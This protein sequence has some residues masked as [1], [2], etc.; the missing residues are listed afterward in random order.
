M[1][2]HFI[3][4]DFLF[5]DRILFLTL[6]LVYCFCPFFVCGF[7]HLFLFFKALTITSIVGFSNSLPFLLVLSVFFIILLWQIK[8][9]VCLL[10]VSDGCLGYKKIMNRSS[11]CW[12]LMACNKPKSSIV[13]TFYVGDR[14]VRLLRTTCGLQTAQISMLWITRSGLSCSVVS[15][16]DK[17]YSTDELKRRLIDVWCSLE[18]SIFIARQHTDARY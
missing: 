7:Y 9:L 1:Y 2:T 10:T 6:L 14:N 4:S 15:S 8:V 18:Q 5:Y 13:D 16:R 11:A 17:I 12:L 3:K